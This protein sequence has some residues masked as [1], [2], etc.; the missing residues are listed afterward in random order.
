MEIRTW[1]ESPLAGAVDAVKFSH[2]IG[3]LKPAPA[4]YGAILSQLGATP[5]RSIFVGDGGS[6][7]LAGARDY[8]FALV[9]LADEAPRTLA[10]H[11]LPELRR[12]AHTHVSDLSEMPALL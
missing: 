4:A 12:Q 9:V 10:P 7:E 2:V 8:G 5:Q 11:T 6:G 1:P 3:H